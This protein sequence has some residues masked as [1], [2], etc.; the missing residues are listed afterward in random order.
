VQQQDRVI[1]RPPGGRGTVIPGHQIQERRGRRGALVMVLKGSLR[2]I[3]TEAITPHPGGRHAWQ[4]SRRRIAPFQRDCCHLYAATGVGYAACDARWASH[5]QAI[6][7]SDGD[8][9]VVGGGRD[10][11]G[12]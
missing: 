7:S 1:E 3:F 11:G 12:T 4:Q 6:T 5:R 2:V 9:Y 10:A 8:Q